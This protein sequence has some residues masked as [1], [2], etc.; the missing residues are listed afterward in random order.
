MGYS[1]RMDK[2]RER[3]FLDLLWAEQKKAGLNDFALA[4]ELGVAHSTISRLKSND[5]HPGIDLLYRAA[6]RF[7]S[8]RKFL[9]IDL[10]QG[11]SESADSFNNAP[12]ESV[13]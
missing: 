12:E 9:A 7:D 5:R 3:K 11:T 10:L 6:E 8:I 2:E 1:A 13:A 4:R